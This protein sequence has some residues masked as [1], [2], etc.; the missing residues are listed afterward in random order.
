MTNPGHD[1]LYSLSYDDSLGIVHSSHLSVLYGIGEESSDWWLSGL[2]DDLDY[3]Q[4]AI[5]YASA[6][7]DSDKGV[8]FT[9]MLVQYDQNDESGSPYDL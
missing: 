1:Q 8:M 5:V 2:P 9:G 3:S 4:A 7:D 6:Y